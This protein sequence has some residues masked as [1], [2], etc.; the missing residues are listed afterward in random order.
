M[1]ILWEL[2]SSSGIPASCAYQHVLPATHVISVKTGQDER[3]HEELGTEAEAEDERDIYLPTS[4]S[5]AGAL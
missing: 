5:M 4:S 1:V 2:R 3:F